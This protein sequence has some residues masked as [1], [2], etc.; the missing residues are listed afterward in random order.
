[1]VPSSAR[2]I[3]FVQESE[4]DPIRWT[5]ST[6]V[7]DKPVKK[8]DRFAVILTAHIGEGWHLYS[9]DQTAGGPIPT[10]IALP[11]GQ[12]FKLADEI[13]APIPRV[14][15]DPVFNLETQFYEGSPEFIVPVI[16][17]A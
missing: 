4:A 15:F 16:Y 6:D 13:D 11:D 2:G 10:R 14:E 3:C 12:G 7:R 5:I 17:R 9:L 1:M 8:G